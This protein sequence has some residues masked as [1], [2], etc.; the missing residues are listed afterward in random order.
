MLTSS[1]DFFSGL[2]W[3]ASIAKILTKKM[4]EINWKNPQNVN[5]HSPFVYKIYSN[6]FKF[7]RLIR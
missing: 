4:V 5:K 1:I 6:L 7:I 2:Q 3:N